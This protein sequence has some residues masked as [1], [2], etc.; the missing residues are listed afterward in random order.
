[1]IVEE[2]NIHGDNMIVEEKGYSWTQYDCRRKNIHGHNTILKEK[3]FMDT[4]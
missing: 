3:I 1:M 2:K 4:I